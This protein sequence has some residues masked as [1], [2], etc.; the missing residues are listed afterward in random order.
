MISKQNNYAFIDGQNLYLSIRGLGWK[1]DYKR[2]MVYLKEK[3]GTRKVFMFLGFLPENRVL[4]NFLKKCGYAL[5]F[6]PT[7]RGKDGDVKGNVDAE[8]VLRA[9]IEYNNYDRAIIIT[10][11]GDFYCLLKYFYK[12]DK[13]LRL[14]VPNRYGYSKLLRRALPSTR[15]ITFMNDLRKLLEY[16]KH[17]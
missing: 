11:D 13:L 9:M 4:Y 6:K 1:L 8:L 7:I 5:I 16:K 10:G 3:Y 15:Y 2:F 12:Q 14:F 17:H